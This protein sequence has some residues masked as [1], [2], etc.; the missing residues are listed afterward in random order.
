MRNITLEIAYDG[1]FYSGWQI[2]DNAITI[3]G[4]LQEAL[5]KI[6]K[7]P[8]HLIASGRTDRGVHAI[9]QVATF[10]TES[11][12][13]TEEFKMA[14][15]SAVSSDIRIVNVVES[16]P[17]FHP[18]YSARR[19][20]YRYIISN[21]NDQVPFFKNYSLWVRRR[22][23][24]D[25]LNKYCKR[26]K[27]KH[28]FKNL[29]TVEKGEVPIREVVECE[30][31]RKNDFVIFDIVANSYLRKMVRFIV[32]TFLQLERRGEKPVRVDDILTSEKRNTLVQSSYAGG[33]YLLKVF[34]Q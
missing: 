17:D 22:L 6:V 15:N 2:Q 33:L 26:I 19:R 34:Y 30:F 8:I 5:A 10:K 7:H 12:M 9:G 11:R 29:G 28:D 14:V 16:L 31:N 13:S 20:W 25:L 23:N 27:G 4:V 18:R 1:T 3:Q 32:G 24:I 21:R